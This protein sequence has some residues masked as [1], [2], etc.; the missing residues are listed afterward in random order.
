MLGV[1]LMAKT[2]VPIIMGSDKD[3]DFAKGIG[4]KLEKFLVPHQYRVCSGEK[5][6][7]YLSDMVA[8]YDEENDLVVY[9]TVAGRSNKLSGITAGLTLNPVIACPP[10]TDKA[11]LQMDIWSTLRAP[12]DSAVMTVL[13]PENAALAAVK[14]L[15]LYDEALRANLDEYMDSV[16]QR[17]EEADRNLRFRGPL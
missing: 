16:R 6:P 3:Y 13:G 4:D 17:I 10:D 5:H 14:I 8:K 12:S 7:A 9:E 1:D 11:A 2:I 15:S